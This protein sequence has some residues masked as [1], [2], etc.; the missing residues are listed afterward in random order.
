MGVSETSCKIG[1]DD[2]C[3]RLLYKGFRRFFPRIFL[4]ANKPQLLLWE[5]PWPRWGA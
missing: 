1:K 4:V 3:S 5:L 2:S